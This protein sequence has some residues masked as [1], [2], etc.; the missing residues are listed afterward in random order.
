MCGIHNYVTS[1]SLVFKVSLVLLDWSGVW[2]YHGGGEQTKRFA[3]E[4]LW[5][6]FHGNGVIW[7]QCQTQERR[8]TWLMEATGLQ[9][10]FQR[11]PMADLK[12]PLEGTTLPKAQCVCKSMCKWNHSCSKKSHATQ[13]DCCRLRGILADEGVIFT[14]KKLRTLN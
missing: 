7:W 12:S 4:K 10:Y 3:L 6:Q 1:E 13:V 2:D 5:L 9:D 14:S 8:L 11:K